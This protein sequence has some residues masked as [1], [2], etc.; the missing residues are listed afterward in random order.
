MFA[1]SII[2]TILL[3]PFLTLYFQEVAA[4]SYIDTS[5]LHSSH[6]TSADVLDFVVPTRMN[7]FYHHFFSE[8]VATFKTQRISER[9]LFFGYSILALT[10][11]TIFNK[12]IESPRKHFWVACF[13]FFIVFSCGV[14]LSI[15]NSTRF[16]L[17]NTDFSIPLF[18]G[19][20]RKI[21]VLNGLR[22]P[23]R[24]D[25]LIVLCVAVLSSF[26]INYY[27]QK[28]RSHRTKAVM[29]AVILVV[30]LIEYLPTP[31]PLYKLPF[32]PILNNVKNDPADCTV[33][34]IPIGIS[35]GFRN[36]YHDSNST[37]M[38]HQTLHG[39]RMFGG[40]VARL[41]EHVF[42]YFQ[43]EPVIATTIYLQ[44]T[45]HARTF[46]GNKSIGS[47]FARRYGLKY[48][49]INKKDLTTETYQ[50]IMRW[51][52]QIFDI[53][54]SW[55]DSDICLLRVANEPNLGFTQNRFNS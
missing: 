54:E 4:H 33:L 38:Y 53:S 34:E 46:K 51:V 50:S 7:Q 19:V 55:H 43:K 18:Y 52:E 12:R 2:T 35:D 27:L 37:H 3:S 1:F 5:S 25:I 36:L 44:R 17:F 41:P 23:V 31:Y 24:S 49:I 16:R 40:Y 26:S 14:E 42:R 15:N 6:F 11:F 28:A 13:V 8:L 21:P 10:L 48:I 45:R 32:S 47:D 9:N 30:F 29:T 39:K 22:T 20:Y